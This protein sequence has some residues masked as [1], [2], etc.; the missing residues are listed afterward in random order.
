MFCYFFTCEEFSALDDFGVF[1]LILYFFQCF[2]GLRDVFFDFSPSTSDGKLYGV[3][4][5]LGA[6]A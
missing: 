3:E 2:P 1:R 5:L 6:A 4:P